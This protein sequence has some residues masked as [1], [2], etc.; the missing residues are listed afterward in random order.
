MSKN[1]LI[2]TL[3]NALFGRFLV[4]MGFSDFISYYLFSV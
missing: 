4:T 1:M 2:N 3:G